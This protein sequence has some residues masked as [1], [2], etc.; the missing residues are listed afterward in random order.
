MP[1]HRSPGLHVFRVIVD[2][3]LLENVAG[4]VKKLASEGEE[5]NVDAV[6]MVVGVSRGVE[7]VVRPIVLIEWEG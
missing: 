7:G 5:S 3:L 6:K 1:V 4:E 2:D